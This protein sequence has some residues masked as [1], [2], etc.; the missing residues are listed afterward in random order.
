MST[1]RQVYQRILQLPCDDLRSGMSLKSTLDTELKQVIG[2]TFKPA[3]GFKVD[4]GSDD[5]GQ[6]TATVSRGVH[7]IQLQGRYGQNSVYAAGGQQASFISYTIRAEGSF[8]NLDRA[9]FMGW[10]LVL[11]ARITGALGAAAL[12]IIAMV[13]IPHSLDFFAHSAPLVAMALVGGQ[14]LGARI[15]RNLANRLEAHAETSPRA[16]AQWELADATWQRLTSGI[17][18]AITG[19]PVVK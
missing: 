17:S 1:P 3:E 12:V 7:T 11:L 5:A 6:L 9:E 8:S 13:L 19:Y 16:T 15:G 14:W 18:S 2:R 10:N 4:V